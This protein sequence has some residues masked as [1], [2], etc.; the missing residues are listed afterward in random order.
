MKS[1]SIK[2]KLHHFKMAQEIFNIFARKT[3]IILEDFG[4]ILKLS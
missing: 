4:G 3:T 1:N 2:K